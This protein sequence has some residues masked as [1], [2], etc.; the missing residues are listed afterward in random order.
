VTC[1]GF[2]YTQRIEWANSS[3]HKYALVLVS[4]REKLSFVE[5]S[6]N[7]YKVTQVFALITTDL[8]LL[9]LRV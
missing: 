2:E 4:L 8:E 1:G 6:V 3:R 5:S 7:A 9:A